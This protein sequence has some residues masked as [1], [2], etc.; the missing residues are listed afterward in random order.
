LVGIRVV[1]W[2]GTSV[3][4]FHAAVRNVL[5][6]V[7]SLPLFYGLAFA[8]ATCNRENRRLGDLAAG[9]LVVH[10]DRQAKPIQVL[11]EGPTDTDR[12]TE[13]LMRQRLVQLDR[14]QKQTLLDLCLRRNQL[15]LRDRARLFH[16]TAEYLRE[17]LELGANPY[18]SDERFVLQAAAVL[19]E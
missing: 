3:S 11:Q 12:A 5:R 13:A 18:Q 9:T 8:V 16:W 19:G 14:R 10:V 17:R 1:R 6:V 15:G 7:D 2:Q 4:F